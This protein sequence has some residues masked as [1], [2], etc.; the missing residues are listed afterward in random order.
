MSLDR[1]VT[2]GETIGK[3]LG[4]NVDMMAKADALY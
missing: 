4:E 2:L 3:P 1:G